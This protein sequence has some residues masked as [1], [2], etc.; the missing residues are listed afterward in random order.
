[1]STELLSTLGTESEIFKTC[2]TAIFDAGEPLMQ[3][4]HEAGTVR[5]DVS[6]NDAVR[7]ISGIAMIRYADPG[8]IDH[9]VA[10]ALDGLRY[11]A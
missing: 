9:L 11:R 1:M 10:V 6:F 8:Q 5:G 3:R 4:A 7:L 2:H